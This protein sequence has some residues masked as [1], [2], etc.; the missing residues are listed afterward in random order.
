MKKLE[1]IID[2]TGSVKLEIKGF[3]GNNCENIA[4]KFAQLGQLKEKEYTE[5]YYLE[6]HNEETEKN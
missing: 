3:F 2:K 4:E 1:I 6:N 5:E